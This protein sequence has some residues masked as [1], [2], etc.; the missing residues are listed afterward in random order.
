M[1]NL[2]PPEAVILY[3]GHFGREVLKQLDI[4]DCTALEL[5]DRLY[6]A[7][8]PYASLIISIWSGHYGEARDRIDMVGF[9]R[10]IPTL[11]IELLPTNIICGPVVQPGY[12]ACY[13]CYKRRM[14]QHQQNT[15]TML[16][17]SSD[18]PEG[19]GLA[20]VFV[21]IGMLGKALTTLNLATSV[22]DMSKNS[23]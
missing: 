17:N 14:Q 11:G 23:A 19:F 9:Q 3:A 7:E 6:P 12:T 2:L 13:D 8:I 5:N 16:D 18:L 20:E 4:K 10:C 22:N 1:S 15:V 21:A